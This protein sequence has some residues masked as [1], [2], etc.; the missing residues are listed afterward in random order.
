M[1]KVPISQGCQVKILVGEYKG[2][3]GDV[4]KITQRDRETFGFARMFRTSAG[5]VLVAVHTRTMAPI[6]FKEAELE[7]DYQREFSDHALLPS[8]TGII[9]RDQHEKWAAII[10]GNIHVHVYPIMGRGRQEIDPNRSACWYRIPN[11]AVLSIANPKAQSPASRSR[12]SRRDSDRSNLVNTTNKQ[13]TG[14]FLQV[15]G[16]RSRSSASPDRCSD[17][18]SKS[19]KRAFSGVSNSTSGKKSIVGPASTHLDSDAERIQGEQDDLVC[20]MG[21]LFVQ[22]RVS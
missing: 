17:P 9:D 1:R 11:V 20:D 22:G 8:E 4:L 2:E 3:T 19:S 6:I 16:T 18:S 12:L 10:D 14:R 15:G 5:R 13:P 7:V 21:D